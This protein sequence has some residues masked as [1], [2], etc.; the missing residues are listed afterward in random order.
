MGELEH[1]FLEYADHLSA[2][3]GG[4]VA[5]TGAVVTFLWRDRRTT[6]N[7]IITNQKNN[8]KEHAAILEKMNEQHS[9]TLKQMLKLHSSD[10]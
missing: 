1:K 10:K 9:E 2:Y 4:V 5:V 3:I 6:K 7:L 8:Q